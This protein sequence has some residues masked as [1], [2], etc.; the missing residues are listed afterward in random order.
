VKSAPLPPEAAGA[1]RAL[2]FRLRLARVE[3]AE[4]ARTIR[5][6]PRA[7]LV[8]ELR[9]LNGLGVAYAEMARALEVTPQAVHEIMRTEDRAGT[10]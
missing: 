8:A 1:L 5:G 7:A 6:E 2:H 4:A 3:A 9:R 10:G